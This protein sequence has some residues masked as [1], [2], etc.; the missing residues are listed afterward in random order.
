MLS[1]AQLKSASQVLDY[2]R[3]QYAGADEA[4]YSQEGKVSGEWSGRL[5]EEMGL[6][7]AVREEDFAS[8]A[9]GRHPLTGEQL[10][11]HRD[12]VEYT[13]ADGKTIKTTERRP[14]VDATISAP[15]S[16]SLTALVGGDERV[17]EVNRAAEDKVI[18]ELEKLTDARLSGDAT[19][20]TEKFVA[21]KFEHHT[22]RPVDGYAAPQL[23]THAIIFNVARRADG[24]TG[25]MQPAEMF[26]ARRFITAVYRAELAAG[27]ERIG[28]TLE[29]G[30]HG[31]FEIAGYTPEYLRAESPRREQIKAEAEARGVSGPQAA[32]LIALEK[33]A[34]KLNLTH[35]QVKAMHRE[36]AEAYGN[37]P[38][39]V[40]QQARDRANQAERPD[41]DQVNRAARQAVR[42]AIEAQSER[43]AAFSERAL[44]TSG[45][46]HAGGAARIDDLRAALKAAQDAG[47]I[48]RRADGKLTTAET[49]RKERDNIRAMLAGK[50][51]VAPLADERQQATAISAVEKAEGYQLGKDQRQAAEQIMS[52][53]DRFTGLDGVAGAGKTTTLSA[54]REA[55]DAS[56]YWVK[57][58][59]PTSRAA[60][61]LGEAGMETTTLQAHLAAGQAQACGL[62]C[63]LVLDE[64]SLASTRQMHQLIQQL[65]PQDRVLFVGDGRQH[66]GVDAGRPF[67]Q[68]VEAGMQTAQLT[69]IR[70]QKDEQ[71]RAA[72]EHLAAGKTQ[73]AV[74]DLARQ[75][76]V[77]EIVNGNDR[78]RAIARDYAEQPEGTLVVSPDNA[79]RRQINQ[80]IRAELQ[81]RGLVDR[82]EHTATVLEASDLTGADRKHAQYYHVGDVLRYSRK[83]VV[84]EAGEFARVVSVDTKKNTVT[85]ERGEGQRIEYDPRRLQGVSAYR[86]AQRQ[87]AQGDRVQ[88]TS[89]N[90]ARQL[91]NRQLGTIKSIERDGS[92]T[93]KFDKDGKVAARTVT[94]AP[95]AARHLDHG[96]AVTSYSS[97]GQT[98]RRVLIHADTT[99]SAALLNSRTAYV[100]VSRGAYEARIYTDD[101]SKLPQALSRNSSHSQA[102]LRPLNWQDRQGVQSKQQQTQRGVVD[103]L[104]S[105]LGLNMQRAGR[106]GRGRAVEVLRKQLAMTAEKSRELLKQF[107]A[108]VSGKQGKQA[109]RAQSRSND[110]GLGL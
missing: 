1:L 49:T 85:V 109:E 21:A 106:Q 96:Y 66:E 29:K 72:V 84:F 55:A 65:G 86:E 20:R 34:A 68:L 95:E 35:D 110:Q 57:G 103:E 94:L 23:H 93:V 54:I 88:T 89:P 45:L 104:R 59:A 62:P 36:H 31:K 69:E 71:L 52:S 27:L 70:R 48:Y 91:A 41:G 8:L 12:A 60:S 11:K 105:K 67:A 30:E 10:V 32:Q 83:S 102:L 26:M 56:G 28:Y 2:F 78:T 3:E 19:E 64:S 97:Q 4:Y 44:L 82:R 87:F 74:A 16:V 5:A 25:A 99:Q 90:K 77:S 101:A 38:Q 15:K 73:Q 76:R 108:A 80:A 92:I 7:G 81:M 6:R 63:L 24:K 79:S 40:V 61:K 53:R 22:A 37:Q 14:A 39:A 17:I 100:S 18:A 13:N 33:R 9:D 51:Q 75:G 107:A 43:T 47:D 58:L 50:S 98:A 42:Y 46:N